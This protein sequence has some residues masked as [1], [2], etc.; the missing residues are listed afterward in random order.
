LF[1]SLSVEVL[2]DGGEG[3]GEGEDLAAG[4][5]WEGERGGAVGGER[6]G[7]FDDGREGRG[8]GGGGGRSG[9]DVEGVGG[10]ERAVEEAVEAAG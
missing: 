7:G 9:R 8:G 1:R 6:G 5:G 4:W 2:E 10:V 3:W